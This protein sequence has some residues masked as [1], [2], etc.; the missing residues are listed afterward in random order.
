MKIT[1][2]V[3]LAAA[4]SAELITFPGAKERCGRLGPMW[5]DPNDLPE[6]MSPLDVRLCAEHPLS[7]ANWW[8]FGQ[9]LPDWV[10]GPLW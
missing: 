8:G 2:L 1:L 6:G 4:A 3:T 10:P 5:F 7:K 9:Y